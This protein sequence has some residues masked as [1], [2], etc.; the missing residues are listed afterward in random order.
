MNLEQKIQSHGG[1]LNMLRASNDRTVIF[2]GIPPEFTNWRDEQRAW[3]HGVVL[4]EQS[5]HMTELHIRGADGLAFVSQFATNDLSNLEPMRA[6]QLVMVDPSGHLISDAIIFGESADFAAG[7][8]ADGE[9]LAAVHR[10][11][12]RP[13]DQ[14]TRNET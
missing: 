11:A 14:V 10:R 2:P 8:P 6:K 7:R 4:F 1:A 5:F 12:I 9:Q 3:H 13:V